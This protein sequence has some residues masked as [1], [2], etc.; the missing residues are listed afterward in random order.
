L[1]QGPPPPP[2][3]PA[4]RMGK[5]RLGS[6]PPPHKA[7]GEVSRFLQTFH[8]SPF[9]PLPLVSERWPSSSLQMLTNPKVFFRRLPRASSPL[10]S[11]KSAVFFF[12]LRH[13]DTKKIGDA[14]PSASVPWDR[15]EFCSSSSPPPAFFFF[16]F[17]HHGSWPLFFSLHLNDEL[18]PKNAHRMNLFSFSFPMKKAKSF[19]FFFSSP[20]PHDLAPRWGQDHPFFKPRI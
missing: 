3:L 8:F 16:F 18:L 2:P 5:S 12:L 14:P 6:F 11:P 17:L 1:K 13:K 15:S 20:S 4:S 7:N 9:S 19:F 10:L